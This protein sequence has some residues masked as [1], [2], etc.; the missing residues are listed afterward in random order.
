[1]R[2]SLHKSSNVSVRNLPNRKEH[3]ACKRNSPHKG[4]LGVYG[5]INSILKISK[6]HVKETPHIIARCV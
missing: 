4:A 2:N 6:R 3:G 5:K 1:M